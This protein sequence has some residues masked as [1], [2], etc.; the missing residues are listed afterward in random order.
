MAMTSAIT[1]KASR[2]TRPVTLSLAILVLNRQRSGYKNW[3]FFH[4]IRW[5]LQDHRRAHGRQHLPLDPIGNILRFIFDRWVGNAD[6][7]V[8]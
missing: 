5:C 2:S 3:K 6:K 1:L 4:S 7:T 8:F